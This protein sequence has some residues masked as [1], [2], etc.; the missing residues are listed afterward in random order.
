MKIK[1]KKGTEIIE[2]LILCDKCKDRFN[3]HK[4]IPRFVVDKTKDFVRT[5]E[6]FSAKWRRHHK[7]HQAKDW[8]DFQRKW[9]LDRYGWKTKSNFYLKNIYLIFYLLHRGKVILFFF[10]T[11]KVNVDCFYQHL[12]NKNP[13]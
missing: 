10:Q 5:E 9:F 3:I 13:K 11:M 8:V 12:G 4:G 2:G 7:N 6:A 1:K